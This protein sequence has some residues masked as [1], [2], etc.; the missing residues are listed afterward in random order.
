MSRLFIA[1][2]IPDYILDELVRI[3][4]KIYGIGENRKWEPS[5]KLHIT[6]KFLGETN[7]KNEIIEIIREKLLNVTELECE[8]E[9]FGLFYRNSSPTILW[10]SIK[11]NKELNSLKNTIENSLAQL[12]FD[13]EKR[14]FKPHITLLRNKT[15]KYPEQ[16]EKFS[17]I[18]LSELNFV[19]NQV[20][21]IESKLLPTGS[22]Y[23]TIEKFELNKT[24]E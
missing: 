19:A 22:E 2:K 1:L 23:K 3:R 12:G 15:N 10:A 18:D 11:Q 4:K 8:L 9:K 14:R 13:K 5:E 17:G 20:H 16:L 6:L 7:K 24:E 21:L